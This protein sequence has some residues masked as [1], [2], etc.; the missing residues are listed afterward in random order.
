MRFL[1]TSDWHLGASERSADLIEDQRFFIDEICRIISEENID[2]VLIAGDIYDRS[3]ASASAVRLY[4]YAMTKICREMHTQVIE[5]AGNHDSA[6]RIS[7]CGE[8][9]EMAGLHVS[10]ALKA[11]PD[12][13]EF[14]D[15]QVFLLPW[16]TEAVVK[17]VFPGKADSI[18]SLTEAYRVVTDVFKKH[19]KEGKRHIAV[20]HCFIENCETSVSD[21]AAEMGFAT[22][23]SAS[24]FDGFD[25]V[26]LGH[27]HRPHSI[28]NR[29]RYSGTPMP[30]SFGVEEAQEKSV[31]IVDTG[32]M[33]QKIVPLPLLHERKTITGTMAELLAPSYP[34]KVMNGYLR[35]EVTDHTIGINDLSLFRGIYINYLELKGR[36]FENENSSISLS[37]DQLERIESDPDELFRHFCRDIIGK[38]PDEHITDLFRESVSEVMQGETS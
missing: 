33:S 25:Y 28:N 6:E 22:Q 15:A 36:S 9:L 1:H 16:I 8:L 5:I 13:V 23:I 14:D 20:S 32:D 2:A 38:D 31:T 7:N 4:D 27:L 24:V 37:V 35:L 12:I 21:R 17:S 34:E 29:I 3:V 18:T 11:E 19:F 30:Y 26:A 10:G